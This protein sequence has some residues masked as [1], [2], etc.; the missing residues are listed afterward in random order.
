[1]ATIAQKVGGKLHWDAQRERF[2]GD[3]DANRLLTKEYRKPWNVV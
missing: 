1:V 3:E 2:I